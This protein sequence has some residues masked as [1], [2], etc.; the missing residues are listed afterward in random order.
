[1]RALLADLSRERWPQLLVVDASGNELLGRPVAVE[2]VIAARQQA[3]LAE[4]HRAARLVE[5]QEGGGS[6]VVVRAG[7][8]GR[9]CVPPIPPLARLT[10]RPGEPP[11]EFRPGFERRPAEPSPWLPVG[12]GLL[13]S[14]AFSALLA[15]YLSKPISNL[16]WALGAVAE[17][18]LETRVKPLMGA[19]R[20]EIADLGQDFDRMAQQLQA[21]ISAQ[22]RLLHDVSHEL[23][24]PLARL[25]A[26]IGLAR[27]DPGKLEGDARPYR[28][29]GGAAR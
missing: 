13:A 22:R 20:D 26:A 24:S 11:R 27:Q 2:S 7:L 14:I 9:S 4:A 16:R 8:V 23:R 28:A 19:R 12:I 25:Q 18:R 17:G 3:A 29:R 1:M 10:E 5:L 15:W 6:L 21:L